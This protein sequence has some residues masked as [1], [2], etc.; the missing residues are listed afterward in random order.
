[1]PR[2]LVIALLA[3][4]AAAGL[5]VRPGAHAPAAAGRASAGGP[6]YWNLGPSVPSEPTPARRRFIQRADRTCARSLAH[7][8][9]AQTAY[10]RRVAGRRDARELVT[11][12]HA[13]WHGREY[14]ALR[15]LGEPPDGR[16][17]YRAFLATI[18]ERV[19]LESRYVPLVHAGRGAEAETLADQVTA[20]ETRGD[21]LG[22]RFGL[23]ACAGEGA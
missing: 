8:R 19:R 6:A 21:A 22:R 1:V 17:E 12:F 9:T 4:A 11:Q 2:T 16:L 18:A 10:A 23:A 14:A 20:L 3:F 15:A 13:R 7:W 5:A